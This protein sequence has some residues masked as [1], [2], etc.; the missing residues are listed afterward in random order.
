VVNGGSNLPA[1]SY[2]LWVNG[3]NTPTVTLSGCATGTATQGVQLNFTLAA[4]A[5]CT[6]T[7]SGNP[8]A[9]Q[10]ENSATATSYIPTP[11]GATASRSAD[12]VLLAGTALSTAIGSATSLFVNA[13]GSSKAGNVYIL[14]GDGYTFM[15]STTS[16]TVSGLS[17]T[18]AATF[19]SLTRAGETKVA[20]AFDGTGRSIVVNNGTVATDA[21]VLASNTA[22]AVGDTQSGAG[23]EYY[24]SVADIALW[25]SRLSNT[26]LQGLT[27]IP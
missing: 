24:G 13:N 14:Q 10:L 8:I 26:T 27:T 21:N 23:N 20:T 18:L 17:P 3:Y 22:V 25:A 11:S 4:P 19:G 16:T 6:V 9:V 5:A 12:Y 7:G 15:Q 1:G 2:T